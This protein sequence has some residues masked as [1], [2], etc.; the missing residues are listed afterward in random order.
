M[1]KYERAKQKRLNLISVTSY[2]NNEDDEET[3][4]IAR[5][6][7]RRPSP[8]RG[9][10]DGE[11]WGFAERACPQ[12]RSPEAQY[13]QDHDKGKPRQGGLPL[14]DDRGLRVGSGHQSPT[15]KVTGE[16]A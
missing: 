6:S 10:D 5:T 14:E 12:D 3:N 9:N 1:K 4:A 8:N 7:S 15:T 11:G 2:T 13:Q 16:A